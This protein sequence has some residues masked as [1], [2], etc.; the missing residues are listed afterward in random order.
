[1]GNDVGRRTLPTSPESSASVEGVV[2]GYHGNMAAAAVVRVCCDHLEAF[3]F[4]VTS[5][6]RPGEKR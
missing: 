2:Q 4:S 1:M 6:L 3:P 5:I